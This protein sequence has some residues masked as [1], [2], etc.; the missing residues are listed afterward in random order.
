MHFEVIGHRG[1]A[2]HAPENTAPSFDLAVRLGVDAIELD[3]RLSRDG[4]PVVIHDAT[5][6][7]VTDGTGHVS[8]LSSSEL[9]SLDAGAWFAEAYRGTRLLFLDEVLDRWAEEIPLVIEIKEP[10]RYG[11]LLSWLLPR[12][13]SSALAGV[14]L[15]SF[16][17]DVLREARRQSADARL[18]WLFRQGEHPLDEALRTAAALGLTQL[19]PHAVGLE[20]DWV[21]RVKSAGYAVRTW[22]I[23][24]QDARDMVRTMRQVIRAGVDGTTADFPDVM[25]TALLAGHAADDEAAST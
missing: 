9:K 4:F 23:P 19:C 25:R 10:T 2:G 11:E 24:S 18:A 15:S 5:V 1:V 21:T 13:Q 12:L 3:V 14:T 6:D 17:L 22:G 20:R 16:S 8:D 7:R